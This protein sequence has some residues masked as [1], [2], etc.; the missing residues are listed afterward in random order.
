MEPLLIGEE[1]EEAEVDVRSLDMFG[2]EGDWFCVAFTPEVDGDY[3]LTI[4][5]QQCRCVEMRELKGPKAGQRQV[6]AQ[7]K[8]GLPS[9][10]YVITMAG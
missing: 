4:C 2:T 3:V 1:E 6:W 8:E 7:P 5:N 10:A 9:G